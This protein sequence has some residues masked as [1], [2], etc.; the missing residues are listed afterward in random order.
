[1]LGFPVYGDEPGKA[2]VRYVDRVGDLHGVNTVVIAC[3]RTDD[4]KSV[5]TMTQSVHAANGT[6]LKSLA[7]GNDVLAPSRGN[8]SPVDIARQ[9]GAQIHP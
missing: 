6:V 3:R 7:I 2:I 8:G 9:A 1:M 5:Y 4:M